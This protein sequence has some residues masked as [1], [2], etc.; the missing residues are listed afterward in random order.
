MAPIV[1]QFEQVVKIAIGRKSNVEFYCEVA[2]VLA[3]DGRWICEDLAWWLFCWLE[4]RQIGAGGP[5]TSLFLQHE[6]VLGVV[7]RCCEVVEGFVDERE[8]LQPIFDVDAVHE[9]GDGL[10]DH[11]HV[12][13]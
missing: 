5:E 9:G 4:P 10:F 1:R 3:D 13:E 2:E 8:R 7:C 6:C 11:D 12:F